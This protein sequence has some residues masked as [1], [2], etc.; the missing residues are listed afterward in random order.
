M[1]FHF[2]IVFYIYTFVLP[3][4]SKR[5][6]PNDCYLLITRPTEQLQPVEMRGL[7]GILNQSRMPK[8]QLL[9]QVL[10]CTYYICRLR[11]YHR[12][13]LLSSSLC[14]CRNQTIIFNDTKKHI[15]Y[16][17]FKK[18]LQNII[19]FLLFKLKCM[20]EYAWFYVHIGKIGTK[21]IN[22]SYL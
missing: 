13:H 9:Q 1:I 15:G 4:E 11:N 14:R 21:N 3:S 17:V 16:K 5:P 10:R 20:W 19:S 6:M 22:S 8:G 18:Q 7:K 12:K 2:Q